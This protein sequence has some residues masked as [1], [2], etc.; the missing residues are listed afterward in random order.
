MD[1][2]DGVFE[3]SKQNVMSSVAKLF[4]MGSLDNI[5]GYRLVIAC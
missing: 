2:G 4:E 5:L 3:T 1:Y